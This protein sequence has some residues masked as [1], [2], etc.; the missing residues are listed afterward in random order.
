M[1]SKLGVSGFI[2]LR[3]DIVLTRS[4][5]GCA[6]ELYKAECLEYKDHIPVD[7]SEIPPETCPSAINYRCI[8]ISSIVMLERQANRTTKV[9]A[10]HETTSPKASAKAP[11]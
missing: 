10:N 8:A 6:S 3:I 2:S 11:P 1:W 5:A 4:I 9:A 7:R